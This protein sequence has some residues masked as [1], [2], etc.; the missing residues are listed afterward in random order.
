MIYIATHNK[1]VNIYIVNRLRIN[2]IS[3]DFIDMLSI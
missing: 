1:L 3:D 2:H